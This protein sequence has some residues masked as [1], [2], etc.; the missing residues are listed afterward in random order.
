MIIIELNRNVWF[1]GEI[2]GIINKIYN[3]VIQTNGRMNAEISGDVMRQ[4][5]NLKRR[6]FLLTMACKYVYNTNIIC[7]ECYYD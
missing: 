2:W 1:I 7:G 5:Q 6:F 3:A 4:R